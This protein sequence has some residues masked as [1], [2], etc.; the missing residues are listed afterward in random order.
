VNLRRLSRVATRAGLALGF[1]SLAGCFGSSS[2]PPA[3]ALDSGGSEAAAPLVEAGPLDAT[4]QEAPDASGI[5][6]SVDAPSSSA[7]PPFDGGPGCVALTPQTILAPA[8]EG[9]PASGLL[10][11]LRADQG[12]YAAPTEAGT[13]SADAAS[14]AQV[15]AWADVSGNGWVLQNQTGAPPTWSSSA[16]GGQPA[17]EFASTMAALQTAGVLG[18]G[19]TSPRTFIAV[20]ALV[21]AGGRFDPIGQ[22]QTGSVGTYIM[23]DANPYGTAGNLEGVYMTSNAFDTNTATMASAAR[24]HVYTV[25]AMTVGTPIVGSVDYRINGV[26][27]TLTLLSGGSDGTFED[28][29]GANFTAVGAS[30]T[31]TT[32]VGPDAFVA[33]V[34]VYDRALSVD[35]RVS[36]EDA[37]ESR[38]GIQ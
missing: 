29:S 32:G 5:E 24:I 12:V 30:Y 34:L 25:S 31:S 22:G 1:G 7:P 3:P 13:P 37:L 26:T 10:L 18:I 16:L 38:Y 20:E 4:S 11:W 2:S 21:N 14:S 17:I 15:C 8:I 6:A 27:Q 28:F 19:A 35:E 9:V 23:I 33:E 36:V